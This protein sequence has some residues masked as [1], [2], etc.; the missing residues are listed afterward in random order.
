MFFIDRK[1][2]SIINLLYK[3]SEKFVFIY[4]GCHVDM[5]ETTVAIP[6]K[7]FP[8]IAAPFKVADLGIT[9]DFSSTQEESELSKDSE[10]T[11]CISVLT[12]PFKKLK[13]M[14]QGREDQQKRTDSKS[15]ISED[16]ESVLSLKFSEALDYFDTLY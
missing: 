8:R 12:K 2:Y 15:V 1:V 10:K 14:L 5:T 11:N 4:I 7:I 3:S 16:S 6:R 9:K 13:K